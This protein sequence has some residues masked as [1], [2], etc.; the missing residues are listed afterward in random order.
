MI[1]M[2]IEDAATFV[3]MVKDMQPLGKAVVFEKNDSGAAYHFIT[4]QDKDIIRIK[5]L[6]RCVHPVAKPDGTVT[7]DNSQLV[8]HRQP[9]MMTRAIMRSVDVEGRESSRTKAVEEAYKK[10][11]SSDLITV[12]KWTSKNPMIKNLQVIFRNKGIGKATVTVK[13][14]N[15]HIEATTHMLEKAGY[16]VV[17][18][19]I[20]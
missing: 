17:K 16:K 6:A 4:R 11:M 15:I 20:Y 10:L 3:A 12:M 2:E 14:T 5:Y 19:H 9:E 7:H 1:T 18:G 13:Y 8:I